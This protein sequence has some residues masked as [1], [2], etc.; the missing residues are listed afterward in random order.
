L[1]EPYRAKS[2]KVLNDKVEP[3]LGQDIFVFLTE[4]SLCLVPVDEIDIMNVVRLCYLAEMVKVVIRLGRAI[5]EINWE[6]VGNETPNKTTEFETFC[7][8]CERVWR[9]DRQDSRAVNRYDKFGLQGMEFCRNLVQ[10]YALVFLR[11]VVLLLHVRYGVAFHNHISTIP[12][13]TELERL[14]EALRLPS[15]EEMCTHIS[16]R[17][18][19]ST[20]SILMD[21]WIKHNRDYDSS[22]SIS[23]GHPAIFELVGLPSK[24]DTLMEET[25]RSRCPTTGKDVSDPMLCLFCGEIFCGQSVCCLK[26]GPA[27]PGGRTQQ[28]GGAQQH[29]FK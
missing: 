14:A 4:C 27:R 11:K 9:G 10:K 8:F 15:F 18:P 20:T 25:M 2:G 17:D 24:Y 3:L 26:E 7:T 22:N 1:N 12:D 19:E 5:S 28:I 23:L 13:G 29:M 6:T 16:D 21:W